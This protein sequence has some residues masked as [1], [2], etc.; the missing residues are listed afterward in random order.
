MV[1]NT[2]NRTLRRGGALQTAA[3]KN[4]FENQLPQIQDRF[5]SAG[6]SRSPQEMQA[7][8]NATAAHNNTV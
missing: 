1:G 2:V 3:N 7:T 8:N 4:L 6:Q 5:V